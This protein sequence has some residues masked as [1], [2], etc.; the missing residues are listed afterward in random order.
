MNKHVETQEKKWI[1]R[2]AQLN[3]LHLAVNMFLGLALVPIMIRYMGQSA[4]GLWASF[5]SV[6]GY[7]GLL[8]LGGSTAT[9]KYTAEYHATDNQEDLSKLI[10]S[11]FVIF[12]GVGALIVFLCAGLAWFIPKLLHVPED[13]IS[14]GRIAFLIMG[15]NIALG[16]AG[17]VFGNVIYGYQRVDVFRSVGIIQAAT[18]AILTVLFLRSGFGLVGVVTAASMSILLSMILYV[19]F[20]RRSGYDITIHPGLADLGIIKKVAPYSLRTFTLGLTAQ[21]LY[22]TDNIVIGIFLGAAMVTPYSI[23][24][25]LCFVLTYMFSVVSTTVFPRFSK[26]YAVGDMQGIRDLYMKVTKISVAIMVPL[27]IFLIFFGRYF[28]S[29]WVGQSNFVGQNVFMVFIVMFFIHSLGASGILLQG[30]GKNKKFMYS[31]ILNA[32]LNLIISVVLVRKIGLIGVALGTLLAHLCTSSWIVPLLACRYIKLPVRT[33]LLSGVIPPL[34]VGVPV[35]VV[36]GVFV[37]NVLPNDCY[38]YI[39]M[40]G[41]VIAVMYALCYFAVGITR[42][43][44]QMYWRLFSMLLW[45]RKTQVA[46]VSEGGDPKKWR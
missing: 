27:A 42:K 19:I 29:L 39:G 25:K 40:K 41:M 23:A 11:V 36:T 5:G 44:R 24:Y 46:P 7:F 37:V 32:C 26:L 15:L 34:L 4:Y 12:L 35:G 43:E 33:F 10:S 6:V 16:L 13:L 1:I 3:Y 17:R 18:N 8:E 31:E 30:I 2:G 21:V 20:I 14:A 9:V 28:I 45:T 22:R 38:I